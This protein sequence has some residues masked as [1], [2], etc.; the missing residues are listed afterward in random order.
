ML[1]FRGLLILAFPFRGTAAIIIS[2]GGGLVVVG[3]VVAEPRREPA[4]APRSAIAVLAR[5]RGE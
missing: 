1:A 5:S 4:V 2:V 3:V